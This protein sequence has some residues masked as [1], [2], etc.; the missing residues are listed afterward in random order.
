MVGSGENY[1]VENLILLIV[2]GGVLLLLCGVIFK[3]G[4]P[5]TLRVKA[6]S[7]PPSPPGVVER[8]G[9]VLVHG[10]GEQRRF[11]HLDSQMRYLLRALRVLEKKG[12]CAR[13]ERRY[14]WE[15]GGRF[16]S[17]PGHMAERAETEHHRND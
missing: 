4:P 15:S 2:A 14:R 10:I 6:Q 12:P 7:R 3:A 1:L 17:G 8:V 9:I 16:R 13:D 11:Q 5:R